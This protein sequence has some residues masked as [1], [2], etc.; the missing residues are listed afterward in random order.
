MD[1]LSPNVSTICIFCLHMSALHIVS[2]N[3]SHICLFFWNNFN[4]TIFFHC[5]LRP[6]ALKSS[7][8]QLMLML[9]VNSILMVPSAFIFSRDLLH[10][11]CFQRT[12]LILR[13][14]NNDGPI[15]GEVSD[16]CLLSMGNLISR[17]YTR[18][19]SLAAKI[20]SLTAN[21]LRTFPGVG[22]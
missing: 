15:T 16:L 3:L 21:I 5:S 9:F 17:S 11:N 20:V 8:L 12:M 14:L 6:C 4:Y 1:C 22:T 2:E 13:V 19:I 10:A 7:R 18:F